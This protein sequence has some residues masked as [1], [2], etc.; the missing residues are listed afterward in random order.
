MINRFLT[1]MLVLWVILLTGVQT[2]SVVLLHAPTIKRPLILDLNPP[3]P[4]KKLDP[5]QDPADTCWDYGSGCYN[6]GRHLYI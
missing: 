1:A 6:T 4:K 3:K 2:G 5:D